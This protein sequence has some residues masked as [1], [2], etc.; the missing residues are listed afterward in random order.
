M[1]S[2]RLRSGGAVRVFARGACALA[3]LPLLAGC[4]GAAP[5]G[6]G[7]SPE[8][9]GETGVRP[10]WMKRDVSVRT[11]DRMF[12]ETGAEEVMGNTDERSLEIL[13]DSEVVRP[14]EDGEGHEVVLD[15]GRWDTEAIGAANRLGLLDGA[16]NGALWANEVTWCGEPV[17]GETFVN[18]YMEEFEDVFDTTEEY[19]ASAADYIDCGDGRP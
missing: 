11:L 8:P 4:G 14:V 5:S 15:E 16:L 17:D 13:L 7:A 18:A 19:E 9:V 3:V 12:A 1:A 6:D 2:D 10:S